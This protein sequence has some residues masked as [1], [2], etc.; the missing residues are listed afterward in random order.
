MNYHYSKMYKGRM[1]LRF[2][3]TN[4]VTEKE[5]FVENIIK[6]LETLEIRPW[7]ITYTS[8]YFELI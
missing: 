3:D 6:D 1:I 2:D 7:K 4:P 8:D 5:E